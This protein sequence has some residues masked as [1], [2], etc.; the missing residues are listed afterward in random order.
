MPKKNLIKIQYGE[1]YIQ[2][3]TDDPEALEFV[4]KWLEFLKE[5]LEQVAE[6]DKVK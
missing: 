4:I 6:G 1:T 3:P 2:A 5:V